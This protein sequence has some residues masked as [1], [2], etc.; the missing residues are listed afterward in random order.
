AAFL[1]PR[2]RHFAEATAARSVTRTSSSVRRRSMILPG[3]TVI[4]ANLVVLFDTDDLRRPLNVPVP[5][6]GFERHTDSRFRRG[7]RDQDKRYGFAAAIGGF[8]LAR[9]FLQDAF[10]RNSLLGHAR[11]DCGRSAGPINN[12][13]TDV[14]AALVR[15]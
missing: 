9:L 3:S 15:N 8:P 10:E 14:V 7:V 13:K 2:P 5:H 4:F 12:I 1:S 11:G 6:H